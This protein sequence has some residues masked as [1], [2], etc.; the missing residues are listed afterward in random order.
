MRARK[1]SGWAGTLLAVIMLCAA[2]PCAAQKKDYLGEVEAD[3]IRDA[4][5]AT[6]RV[7]LY[8]SFAG[9][10]LKK[11]E[12]E[13]Q[14]TN[15]D[16][17]WAD[18]LNNLFNA[19][20]GCLDDAADTLDAAIEKLEDIRPAIKEMDARTNEFR[21]Y[22]DKLAERADLPKFKDALDDAMEATQDAMKTVEKAAKAVPAAPVRRSPS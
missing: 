4:E 10:R 20:S 2:L 12:Y 19:Y 5:T 17:L 8:L 16:R 9:D 3:K 21:A 11:I 1:C 18:R 15:R 22:L 7:K 13:L 6:E 14:R